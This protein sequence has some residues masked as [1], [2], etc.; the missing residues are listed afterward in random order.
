MAYKLFEKE[1]PTSNI[2][3]DV[4]VVVRIVGLSMNASPYE[5]YKVVI[6]RKKINCFIEWQY[7]SKGCFNSVKYNELNVKY[8]PGSS[9]VTHWDY[10]K[11]VPYKLIKDE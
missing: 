9:Y 10:L 5:E 11:E 2:G 7:D 4:N 8:K 6:W 1:K 3:A